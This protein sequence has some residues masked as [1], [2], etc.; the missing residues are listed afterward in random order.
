MIPV[1]ILVVED[2]VDLAAAV[3]KGLRR[4]GH[5]LDSASAVVEAE[6]KIMSAAY[7]LVILDWGLP[8]GTG[9][10]LCKR[11]TSG[12]LPPFGG[13]RPRVLM[14]TA[15]DSVGD[16][17]VGLDAG[18]DDYLVKP[19]AFAELEARVRALLRRDADDAAPV[20]EVAGIVLDPGRFTVSREGKSIE[21]T[22]KEFAV[23]EYLMRNAGRV[24][25]QEALLEHCW[26]EMADPFTNTVRVTMSNL[27]KKLG[28]PPVIHTIPNRG[29]VIRSG[30]S[31]A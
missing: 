27:R 16:R 18:A 24:L 22:A 7:D 12:D 9:L 20:V 8:D 15:R 10:D 25:S 3:V 5:G 1:R 4:Q 26:D 30:L 28:A 2:E 14:L 17:V 29:Y 31:P 11:V 23:L 21:L 13:A 19:F 6:Q